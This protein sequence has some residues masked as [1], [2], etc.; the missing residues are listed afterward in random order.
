MA[1]PYHAS[2]GPGPGKRAPLPYH[3][4]LQSC[5]YEVN[6][7]IIA[8][9]GYGTRRHQVSL[10]EKQKAEERDELWTKRMIGQ[11]KILATSWAWSTSTCKCPTRSSH[12]LSMRPGLGSHGIPI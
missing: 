2:H 8:I 10:Q 6:R 3:R 5:H 9:H 12:K 7:F 4:Y 1:P 11:C